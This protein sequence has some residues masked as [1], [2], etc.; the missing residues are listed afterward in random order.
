MTELRLVIYQLEVSVKQKSKAKC[1]V[2]E[3]LNTRYSHIKIK[4]WRL[5]RTIL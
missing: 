2:V 5:K 1:L 3:N 4:W